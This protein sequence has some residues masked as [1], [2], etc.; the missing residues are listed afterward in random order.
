[1]RIWTGRGWRWGRGRREGGRT[2][3]YRAGSHSHAIPGVR[4]SFSQSGGDAVRATGESN[5][6][7][8]KGRSDGVRAMI[9][10]SLCAGPTDAQLVMVVSSARGVGQQDLQRNTTFRAHA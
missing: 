9:P 5:D 7:K 10:R 3:E 4:K 6:A 1:M 2:K 8:T